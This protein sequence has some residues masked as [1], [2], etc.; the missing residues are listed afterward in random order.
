MNERAD[1]L[2]LYDLM[3]DPSKNAC[4]SKSTPMDDMKACAADLML[5]EGGGG[6]GVYSWKYFI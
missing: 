2:F 4:D 5:G 6:V 3:R 1:W